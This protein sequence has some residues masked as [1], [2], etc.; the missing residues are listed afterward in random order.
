MSRNVAFA[1]LLGVLGIVLY[2]NSGSGVDL[3][4]ARPPAVQLDDAE[5]VATISH[6]EEVDL[7][8]H[9]RDETWTLVEFTAPW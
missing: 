2:R 6:G 5:L 4:D 1:A 7:D 3:T 8:G 9:L